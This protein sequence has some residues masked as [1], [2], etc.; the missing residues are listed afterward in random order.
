MS[1]GTAVAIGAVSLAAIGGVVYLSTRPAHAMALAKNPTFPA[2]NQPEQFAPRP[3]S[4]SRRKPSKRPIAFRVRLDVSPAYE[5]V[6]LFPDATA[7]LYRY[8]YPVVRF[9]P[10]PYPVSKISRGEGDLFI[11]ADQVVENLVAR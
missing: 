4:A 3:R 1:T 8:R 9:R 2:N 6:V 7:I 10:A 11:Y 5:A